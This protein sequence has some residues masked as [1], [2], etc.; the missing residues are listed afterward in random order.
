MKTDSRLILLAILVIAVV[1]LVWSVIGGENPQPPVVSETIPTTS[2]SSTA[3]IENGGAASGEKVTTAAPTT[4]ATTTTSTP[5]TTT[6]TFPTPEVLQDVHPRLVAIDGWLQTDVE[7]LEELRGQVVIVEFWTFGCYNCKNR[8]PYT[9]EMYAKYQN[10]GLEIVGIHSP[11]FKFEEDVDN[12]KEAMVD[13]GVTWPVVLDTK[14]RTFWE[15]QTGGTAY[16]PRTYVLDRDG[17]VRFDHIG[18]GK[19]R[20]LEQTVVFLLNEEM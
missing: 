19:Y 2:P 12:I 13:L 5:P 7:S 6:T 10:Q 1:A 16:W 11:E 8:I 3:E 18:E 9:Q 15:W 20:E 4:V 17:R 14:R